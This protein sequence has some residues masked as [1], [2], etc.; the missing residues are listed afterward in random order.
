[1]TENENL[2]P[3]KLLPAYK[4]RFDEHLRSKYP[5]IEN[6]NYG[7]G[8]KLLSKD[9]PLEYLKK[10]VKHYRMLVIIMTEKPK[11]PKRDIGKN[12]NDPLIFPPIDVSEI[13]TKLNSLKKKGWLQGTNVDEIIDCIYGKMLK[14]PKGYQ[15][16]LEYTKAG[17]QNKLGGRWPK[18]FSL[19]FLIF[20]LVEYM[21]EVKGKPNYELISNF[22]NEQIDREELFDYVEV[23]KKYKNIKRNILWNGYNLLNY[24]FEREWFDKL[25]E[26]QEFPKHLGDY[27]HKSCL[28]EFV[29]FFPPE[30]KK[31][32]LPPIPPPLTYKK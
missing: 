29:D 19:N 30:W 17:F 28:P 10:L 2:T 13:E 20:F 1:M 4:N 12:S 8:T 32:N 23:Q 24:A 27:F 26:C 11:N 31:T 3:E 5:N 6:F 25:Y 21:K 14:S 9:I 16:K 15:R 18:N 22:L 7:K